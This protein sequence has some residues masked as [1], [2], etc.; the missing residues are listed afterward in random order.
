MKSNLKVINLEGQKYDIG[1]AVAP[2]NID[3]FNENEVLVVEQMIEPI[4]MFGN[5]IL[6][7]GTVILGRV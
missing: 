6:K 2:L 5:S 1:M 3:Q 7:T 4:I